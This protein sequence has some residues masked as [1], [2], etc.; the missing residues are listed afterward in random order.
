[1]LRAQETPGFKGCNVMGSGDPDPRRGSLCQ[2]GE[3]TWEKSP[4]LGG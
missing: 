4:T 2:K 1:M 3:V